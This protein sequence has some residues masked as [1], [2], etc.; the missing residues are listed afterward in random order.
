MF[1]NGINGGPVSLAMTNQDIIN[2]LLDHLHHYLMSHQEMLISDSFKLSLKVLSQHHM[3]LR[4][5][6]GMLQD[7]ERNSRKKDTYCLHPR[8]LRTL[9]EPS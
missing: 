1:Q 5:S 9:R 8:V 3:R 6:I 7:L 4:G 2:K